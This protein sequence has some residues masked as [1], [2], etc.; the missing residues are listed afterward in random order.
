MISLNHRFYF[1]GYSG[2]LL[3]RALR[4]LLARTEMHRAWLA[5]DMGIFT[6]E[7][8]GEEVT[9]GVCDRDSMHYRKG[10][11]RTPA[12]LLKIAKQLLFPFGN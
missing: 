6:E 11:V 2:L 10:S 9:C 4:R 1:A 8:W 12:G 3:P 5:G 7:R